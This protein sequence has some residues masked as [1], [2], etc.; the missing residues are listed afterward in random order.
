MIEQEK[1]DL[2]PLVSREVS[3]SG[4]SEELKMMLELTLLGLRLL[5][6]HKLIISLIDRENH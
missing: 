4:A 2:K 3:L 6:F 1:V 5:R